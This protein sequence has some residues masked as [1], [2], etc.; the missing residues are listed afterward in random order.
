MTAFHRSAEWAR[1]VRQVKPTITASINAGTAVCVDCGRPVLP[2]DRWQVGHRLAH[3][4]HPQFSLEAW[5]VGPS[6]AGKCNQSK[7][8]TLGN[9]LRAKRAKRRKE[10]I[11]WR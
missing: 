3:A 4:T 5:N 10:F 11:A 7:G 6:H 1:L 2:G 9:N 8:A